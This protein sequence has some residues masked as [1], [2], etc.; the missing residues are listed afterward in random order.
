MPELDSIRGL[1]ILGVLF[2]HGFYYATTVSLYHS[3]AQRFVI[4]A[5]TLGRTGV[6]LFFVLSGFLITGILI[7]SRQQSGC[8]RRFY[9]RR[10]LRILPAYYGVLALL[11]V[12][13]FDNWP[14][15]ALSVIYLSNLTPLW[16]IPLAYSV[17]WSLAVE[18]HFYLFWPTV[19]KK[20]R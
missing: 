7:D 19:V 15:V 14:F 3:A 9:V 6:N 4:H 13:H 17:L 2:T 11:L 10:A 1:A 8:Y 16:G 12:H 18:E 20:S 5:T